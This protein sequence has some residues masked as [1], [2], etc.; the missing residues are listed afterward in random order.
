MSHINA[1]RYV[2]TKIKSGVSDFKRFSGS[3]IFYLLRDISGNLFI[4]RSDGV[5]DDT[6]EMERGPF[7]LDRISVSNKFSLIDESS[8]VVRVSAIGLNPNN[9]DYPRYD[10]VYYSY[11]ESGTWKNLGYKS[12]ID[13]V[14]PS[15]AIMVKVDSGDMFFVFQES[16]NITIYQIGVSSITKKSEIENAYLIDAKSFGDDIMIFLSKNNIEYPSQILDES[17]VGTYEF[18]MN[19][20]SAIICNSSSAYSTFSYFCDNRSIFPILCKKDREKHNFFIKDDI[21]YAISVGFN[22]TLNMFVPI[23]ST[24]EADDYWRRPAIMTPF[25]NISGAESVYIFVN[26]RDVI[27]ASCKIGNDYYLTYYSRAENRWKSHDSSSYLSF[28]DSKISSSS[29]SES[30]S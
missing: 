1:N 28:D 22:P 12:L 19:S 14:D 15:Y 17:S 18:F 2:F 26:S 27:F 13:G 11:L 4:K 8:G 5:I 16:E 25:G 21:V 23:V 9:F 10:K 7:D 20:P 3:F 30:S 6:V 24:G 29:S